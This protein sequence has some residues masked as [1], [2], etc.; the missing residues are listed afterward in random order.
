MLK[1]YETLQDTPTKS[2]ILVFADPNKPYTLFTDVSQYTW[3]TLSM[4]NT[5][6]LLMIKL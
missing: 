1:A 6:L 5:P 2:P 4:Q 3:S